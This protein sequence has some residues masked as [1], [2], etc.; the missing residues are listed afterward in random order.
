MNKQKNKVLVLLITGLFVLFC[1]N[2]IVKAE[3]ESNSSVYIDNIRRTYDLFIPSTSKNELLPLVIVLHGGGSW[4]KRMSRYTKFNELAEKENFITVFPDAYKGNWNDG[5]QDFKTNAHK[6]NIDDLKFITEII[7]KL[8]KENHA[9]KNKVY[10][11]G[12]S[13]GAMMTLRIGCELSDKI[14][15]I[16]SVEGG[17]PV[18][19]K[20]NPKENISLMMI[21]GTTD[22]VVPYNGGD[23]K[24]IFQKR[25]K[26]Q[27]VEKTI[28]FWSK[29]N[30]CQ[31]S[32]DWIQL[33]DL[34]PNDGTTVF[35]KSSENCKNNSEV[36]LYK[37]ENGGHSWAGAFE[38]NFMQKWLAGKTSRDI[39]ATK[40]IWEFFKNH[41]K[42]KND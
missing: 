3:E 11:A 33:P 15:A 29:N 24:F 22:P 34:D 35:K 8:V 28:N 41:K 27:P 4:G 21:N 6:S 42:S 5:R 13:N 26:I 14:S 16:A 32:S 7:N 10:V 40:V 19:L 12:I 31:N 25:G 18:D 17:L 37:I 38:Y 23:I 9:D 2:K 36:I 1:F 39:D 20:C 30:Q